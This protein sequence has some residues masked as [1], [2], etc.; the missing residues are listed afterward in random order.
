MGVRRPQVAKFLNHML[1][2]ISRAFQRRLKQLA[3][4][5]AVQTDEQTRTPEI[6]D[7][8][9]AGNAYISSGNIG[10]AEDCFRRAFEAAPTDTQVMVCL[11]YVLKEQGRWQE[12]RCYLL[13]AISQSPTAA[14]AFEWHY[15]LGE[16]NELEG[17]LD[18][19]AQSFAASLRLQPDFSRACKELC[20]LNERLGQE[21]H[22]RPLLEQCVIRSPSC[23]DY[24]LW[25]S[26][27]CEGELDFRGVVD[28]LSV[29]VGLGAQSVDVWTNL[30]AAYYRLHQ[31]EDACRAFDVAETMDEE[32]RWMR[33]YH[34]GYFH[35][36]NGDMLY[37]IVEL[38]KAIELNSTCLDAHSL[39]IMV[40]SCAGD[41]LRPAYRAAAMRF[42]DSVS[43]HQTAHTKTADGSATKGPVR[44]GFL[45][46]DFRMHPVYH[47]FRDLLPR[48]D[49]RRFHILAFSNNPINDDATEHLRA[50]FDEWYEIFGLGDIA[51]ANLIQST[52]V[53][54]LVDLGGHTSNCRLSVFAQKPAPVQVSW[55]GYFAS[56]GLPEIDY[57]LADNVSVPPDSTEWFSERI[58]R[59]PRTRLCMS[60]PRTNQA[61]AVSD[62]PFLS[63][64]YITFGC[65]QQASKITV[66]VLRVWKEILDLSPTSRLRI[67][68]E[69]LG[70]FVGQDRIVREM[71]ALKFE[72]SRVDLLAPENFESYLQAHSQ[73]DI[74]LD[75]FPYPGG[76][77]TAFA[78]WMGVPT[79]TLTGGTML[80]RQGEMMLRCVAL[81]D[82][83]ASNEVD[84]VECA[85]TMSSQV[86]ALQSLRRELRSRAEDSPL[87]DSQ[88]FTQQL[89]TA[90]LWMHA[91]PVDAPPL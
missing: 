64:G 45:S 75:T 27:L 56:T 88:A 66:D 15:L 40:L 33:H 48:F 62:T 72:M 1:D 57:I 76:T 63:R 90:F 8:K 9:A 21:Q 67:Q 19:A 20:R 35:V 51:A 74:I 18:K 13:R 70:K 78:L 91:N 5:S 77:T 12:A 69:G 54:V 44:V 36:R 14:D 7:F 25:L 71:K 49:R 52:A 43:R 55:L 23:L 84:Y 2:G 47:F 59:L 80:A 17:D 30:A 50:L 4:K 60:I 86:N 87:F 61:I 85:L 41:D 26:S 28:H 32:T 16:I 73:I 11:A 82:W 31:A 38:S 79:V 29:A 34:A 6:D 3:R 39:L 58:Y 10:E 89:E 83:I 65:F 22:V 46:S 24:R 81:D 53:D 42:A 68:G 37:A